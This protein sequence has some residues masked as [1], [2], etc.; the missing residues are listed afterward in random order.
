MKSKHERI[1]HPWVKWECFKAGFYNTSPP[2]GLDSDSS[3]EKYRAFLQ[4][5]AG[6][7]VAMNRVAREWPNSCEQF[8]TNQSMNRIAWLGQAAMCITHGVPSVFRH[9]FKLLTIEEQDAANKCAEIFLNN[10]LEGKWK[11][12]NECGSTLETG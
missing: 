10:W 5:L 2:E 7:E 3:A 9:G 12:Q 1:Y 8:L 6:F 4:D 11:Q